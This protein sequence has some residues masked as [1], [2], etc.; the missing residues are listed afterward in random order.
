MK[1]LIIVFCLALFV[2]GIA[3]AQASVG[4]TMY[5]STKTVALKASTGFF[6]KTNFTLKYG[7]RVTIIQISGKNAEV[8][9][10]ASSSQRGWT[11]IANLSARQ[12]VSGNANAISANEVALAGK[13]FNQEVENTY[14]AKGNLNYADVDKV[15]T[16][17]VKEEDLQKFM[18]EGRL[19]VGE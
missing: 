4:G 11:A 18:V 2:I 19:S 17:S 6:A 5:V 1:K 13:G 9:N 12:I 8:R 15:E 14:K 16:L 3:A 7:D 10:A